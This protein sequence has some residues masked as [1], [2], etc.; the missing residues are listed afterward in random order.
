MKLVGGMTRYRPWCAIGATITTE[1]ACGPRSW[2]AGVLEIVTVRHIV[3]ENDQQ[4]EE[5]KGLWE[6]V[7]LALLKEGVKFKQIFEV[8][9][10]E[11]EEEE[12][13]Y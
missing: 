4:T 11:E 1:Y 2:L 7:A 9:R 5:E 12:D 3:E 13:G 10:E 8:G 6:S